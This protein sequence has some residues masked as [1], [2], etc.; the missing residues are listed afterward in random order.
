MWA[1][2]G[3]THPGRICLGV[4]GPYWCLSRGDEAQKLDLGMESG[5]GHGG[6]MWG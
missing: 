4:Q 2:E 6:A 5:A 1:G 3:K